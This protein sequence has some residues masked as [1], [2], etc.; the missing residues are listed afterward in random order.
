MSDF[1]ATLI[2]LWALYAVLVFAVVSLVKD[3][4][5]K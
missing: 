2:Y 3:R 5:M 1:K 4:L